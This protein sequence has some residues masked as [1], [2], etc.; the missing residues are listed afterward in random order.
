[1][2][3]PDKTAADLPSMQNKS[4]NPKDVFRFLDLA[5]EIRDKIYILVLQSTLNPPPTPEESGKRWCEKNALGIADPFKYE[6][7]PAAYACYGLLGSNRQITWEMHEA[8]LREY[9][10]TYG[11]VT[12]KL[13]CMARDTGEELWPT[14]LALPAPP[15]YLKSL[16]VD[17]R[18]LPTAQILGSGKEAPEALVSNLLHLLEHFV[19]HGPGF[20]G[21]HTAPPASLRLRKLECN[22]VR[23]QGDD[24]TPQKKLNALFADLEPL[25][26]SSSLFEMLT[27]TKYSCQGPS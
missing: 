24:S 15:R 26:S 4:P 10:D 21:S 14:W 2:C 11:G 12:Y 27:K 5:R 13:D 20:I 17:I 25:V 1:M 23:W 7:K 3:A 22:L 18:I 9:S 19:L 8:V 16:E 6:K